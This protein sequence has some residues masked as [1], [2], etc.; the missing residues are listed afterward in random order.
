MAKQKSKIV[1]PLS[2]SFTV[3][4]SIIFPLIF[5][6]IF[7]LL[8]LIFSM[9]DIVTA[10]CISYRQLI[11]SSMKQQEIYAYNNS[12]YCYDS[13]ADAAILKHTAVFNQTTTVNHLSMKSDVFN[14]ATTFSNYNN[15]N[16]L[17]ENKAL[18][19]LME[20]ISH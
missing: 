18:S 20:V 10:K 13:Y 3:E 8:S 7:Q 6:V 2:G 19:E 1:V 17:W 12:F 11:S 9:H 15:T 5:I 14:N 16:V 4:A